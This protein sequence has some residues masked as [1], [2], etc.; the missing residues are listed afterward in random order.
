MAY[1]LGKQYPVDQDGVT[2]PL[3]DDVT[4]AGPGDIVQLIFETEQVMTRE[5]IRDV[6]HGT[7]KMKEEYPLFVLHYL[8]IDS[9]KITAQ[10]SVAPYGAGDVSAEGGDITASPQISAWPVIPLF[11]KIIILAASLAGIILFVLDKAADIVNQKILRRPPA[12]GNA[13]VI[14]L[15][16]E[17]DLPIPNVN[18]TVAGQTKK[19]GPNGEAAFFKDLIIGTYTVIGANVTGYQPPETGSVTVIENAVASCTLWYAPDDYVEPTHGWLSIATARAEG[20]IYVQGEIVGKPGYAYVYLEKDDYDVYFGP[21]EGYITPPMVTL[22]VR[23]DK[24]TSYVAYYEL[25]L[26]EWW[27]KYAKYILIG[28]GAII[29]T[30]ILLPQIVQIATRPRREPPKGGTT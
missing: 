29:G 24:V 7:L 5:E 2:V 11:V 6:I 16:M 23:G 8:K 25:P 1:E 26:T 13:E 14:A 18:I 17:S 15:D 21:V 20:D 4:E 12:T 27:L 9:R 30:A 3:N 10:F 28:G 19:T 22:K